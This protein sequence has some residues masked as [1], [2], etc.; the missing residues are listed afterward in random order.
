M[1]GQHK[2]STK[3]HLTDDMADSIKCD[4]EMNYFLAGPDK[5]ADMERSAKLT[6]LIH[7]EFTDV[8]PDIG[9]F[10]VTSSLQEM[11]MTMINIEGSYAKEKY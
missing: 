9:C 1:S 5:Q 8:F 2:I 3:K 11:A 6:R 10:K 7:C 4:I